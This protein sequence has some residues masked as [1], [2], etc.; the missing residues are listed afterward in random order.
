MNRLFVAFTASLLLIEPCQANAGAWRNLLS[1]LYAVD[2]IVQNQQQLFAAAA[3]CEISVNVVG[4]LSRIARAMPLG[5]T[6]KIATGKDADLVILHAE[7][8]GLPPDQ[9]AVLRQAVTSLLEQRLKAAGMGADFRPQGLP[10]IG[11]NPVA[12]PPAIE[13]RR[14][15][16]PV[17]REPGSGNIAERQSI[18]EVDPAGAKIT[19]YPSTAITTNGQVIDQRGQTAEIVFWNEQLLRFERQFQE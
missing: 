4:G 13:F 3:T 10:G 8:S 11:E 16:S 9:I 7:Q 15:L 19:L 1:A 14:G 17:L 12:R 5:S 6:G 18:I 2:G